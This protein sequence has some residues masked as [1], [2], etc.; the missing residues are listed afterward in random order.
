MMVMPRKL[1]ARSS[2]FT[3]IELLVVIAIIGILVAL[4][5][6]AVQQTREAAR[7][8]QCRN[9]LKQM[10][11]ALHN[12]ADAHGTL[13]P[14]F[15]AQQEFY[16]ASQLNQFGWG[17]LLLPQLDQASLYKKLDPN[18]MIWDDSGDVAG[19][20]D[21]NQDVAETS[22]TIFRCPTERGPQTVDR[23][24]AASPGPVQ[25]TS[26][27]AAVQGV[28]PMA[29]PCW[30]QPPGGLPPL[31]AAFHPMPQP[32]ENPG[33]PFFVNSRTRLEDVKDGT[34]HTIGIGEVAWKY[35]SQ[36]CICCP[37]SP[38]GGTVWAG[39]F[40]AFRSEMVLASTIHEYYDEDGD[41]IAF[42]FSSE[43]T[44]GANFLF[45]DGSVRLLNRSIDSQKSIPYGVF[46][47][48]STIAGGETASE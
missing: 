34:S 17:T 33:G 48:L 28:T 1:P 11:L 27:Y 40:Y 21:T 20:V 25:A 2:G 39:V 47:H 41:G 7:R 44:E 14:G 35:R 23:T 3:L 32:C 37:D 26:S 10:G 30:N 43:H 24:C 19:V 42:G 29:L 15:I 4:L 22:L 46:Q 6:P 31:Q 36:R 13:P 18:K 5:L 38:F 16:G 9:H 45:L 12:Y 8:L